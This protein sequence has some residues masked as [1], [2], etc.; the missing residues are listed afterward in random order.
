MRL[1]IEDNALWAGRTPLER[2]DPA[3]VADVLIARGRYPAIAQI[4]AYGGSLDS[5]A[6]RQYGKE[7]GL[8][9]KERAL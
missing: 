5:S 1:H 6:A 8:L 3:H 9:E 2:I 4:L 7:L